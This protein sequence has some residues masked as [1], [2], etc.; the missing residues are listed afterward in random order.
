VEAVLARVYQTAVVADERGRASA[1]TGDFNGDNSQDIA[2]I[3]KPNRERLSEINSE[4]A[5]WILEDPR[6]V[7]TP[8]TAARVDQGAP[9]PPAR[10]QVEADDKLIAIIHGF[11]SEGW[12][13]TDAKQTYLLKNAVGTQM[14]TQ[15]RAEARRMVK[16]AAEAQH[17]PFSRGDL[18]RQVL[19]SKAGY[20]YWTGAKYAWYDPT[21]NRPAAK[22]KAHNF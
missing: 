15:S 7:L 16:D 2:I 5:N 18:I 19:D 3:V 4:L 20:L 8:L 6:R 17:L 12:R 11:R 10:A 21:H 1:L 22:Q 13:N 9:H 14:R